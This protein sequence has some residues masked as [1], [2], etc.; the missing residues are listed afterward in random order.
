MGDLTQIR[1]GRDGCV[2]II[3]CSFEMITISTGGPEDRITENCMYFP[4]LTRFPGLSILIRDE[5]IDRRARMSY[6][7]FLNLVEGK[8]GVVRLG[9]CPKCGKMGVYEDD[10]VVHDT[11]FDLVE[12]VMIL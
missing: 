12:E 8:T 7:R 6:S 5:R 1:F 2:T 9:P 4:D 11:D 10:K 3:R